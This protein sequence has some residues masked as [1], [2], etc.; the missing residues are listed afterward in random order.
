M[1]HATN[2]MAETRWAG[3]GSNWPEGHR[4]C[5]KCEEIKPN[6]CFHKHA[7]CKGGYNS[8]C[9][10]CRVPA[11][12]RNY[13]THSTQYKLWYRAKRRAS[14]KGREFSLTLEDIVVPD[15]CP[16]FGIPFE[17]NTIY[18]ASLDR[19]DSTKGY[20]KDNIQVLSS[21]AN[22]LKN[23]ASL[24]ELVALVGFLQKQQ[25]AK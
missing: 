8:V 5:K 7:K 17:D 14:E 6:S 4:Q 2:R 15:V 16:V 3:Y 13:L 21:R 22:T 20:T 23:N 18:A 19:I 25:I 10:D 11:S 24:E 12:Q 1:S 9:K